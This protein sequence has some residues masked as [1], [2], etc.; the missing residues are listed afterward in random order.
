[1]TR[2]ML[3]TLVKLVKLINFGAIGDGSVKGNDL[4]NNPLAYKPS[5]KYIASCRRN[6]PSR[7]IAIN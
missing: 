1:M 4:R 3:V 7:F 5:T 2:V 6:F